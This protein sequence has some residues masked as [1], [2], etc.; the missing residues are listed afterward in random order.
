MR[1]GCHCS[2][3]LVKNMVG[4]GPFLERFQWLILQVFRKLQLPG[5]TRV[6]FGIGSSKADVDT[7]IR[8]LDKTGEK[9]STSAGNKNGSPVLTKT[10][11]EKQI[12]EF[13]NTAAEKVYSIR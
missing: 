1:S 10:E 9:S 13:V 2:H 11:I 6:S 4:V 7:L 5:V 3:I 12:K 8:V